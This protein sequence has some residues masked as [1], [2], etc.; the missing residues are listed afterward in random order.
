VKGLSTR[1][2]GNRGMLLLVVATVAAAVALVQPVSAQAGTTASVDGC[3]VTT[4][5]P[6]IRWY[7]GSKF[8][9]ADMLVYCKY[10]RAG[11]LH[12]SLWEWD[13][14]D[15]DD[16]V[17]KTPVDFTISAGTWQSFTITGRCSGWD[18]WGS[19]VLYAQALLTMEVGYGQSGWA[20]SPSLAADC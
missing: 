12:M 18:P 17:R 2:W 3:T 14:W 5:A 13:A 16:Q 20:T 9:Q 7:S 4:S 15:A 11:T 1:N 8:V 10:R 19:E 6:Y